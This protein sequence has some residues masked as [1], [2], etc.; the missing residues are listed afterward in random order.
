MSYSELPAEILCEMMS[1]L[2]QESLASLALVD[3]RSLDLASDR[4]ESFKAEVL[5]EPV[6]RYL[7]STEIGSRPK[8]LDLSD[9]PAPSADLE[10]VMK[11]NP[12]LVELNVTNTALSFSTLWEVLQQLRGL[13]TLSFTLLSKPNYQ[14]V[15]SRHHLPT[16]ALFSIKNLT[17]E[18]LPRLW[19][20]DVLVETL[21]RCPSIERVH[22]NAMG[23]AVDAIQ[24]L[25]R[26]FGPPM[27]PL[28]RRTLRTVVLTTRLL[29]NPEPLPTEFAVDFLLRVLGEFDRRIHPWALIRKDSYVYHEGW[30][31]GESDA[32][33]DVEWIKRVATIDLE[34]LQDIQD[35]LDIP[36]KNPRELRIM[37][38]YWLSPERVPLAM[39]AIGRWSSSLVELDMAGCHGF[40]SKTSRICLLSSLKALKNLIVSVCFIAPRSRSQNDQELTEEDREALA[41]AFRKLNLRKL[42][43]NNGSHSY[44]GQG[45]NLSFDQS[46]NL[47]LEGLY[48]KT[49]PRLDELKRLEELTLWGVR[50]ANPVYEF[51]AN[52][53][54]HTLRLKFVCGTDLGDFRSFAKLCEN[55]QTLEFV[56]HWSYFRRSRM[57]NGFLECKALKRL[58]LRTDMPGRITAARVKQRLAAIVSRLDVLHLHFFKRDEADSPRLAE[59]VDQ[60]KRDE[61]FKSLGEVYFDRFCMPFCHDMPQVLRGRDICCTGSLIGTVKPGNW[62]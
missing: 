3:R 27:N 45:N 51:L 25:S 32:E 30:L 59:L 50:A 55:L 26:R 11:C 61:M 41:Q 53:V 54:V 44:A 35:V 60:L 33:P 39:A 58:C 17:V 15:F 22:V 47:C 23:F 37:R 34:S 4:L 28:R 8:S 29:R 19:A 42:C 10:F 38:R 43:V 31:N 49:L 56:D 62:E 20:N 36:K 14:K 52:P 5:S 7:T 46:C 12:Q 48:S 6:R 24:D 9:C 16:C 40:H 21:N 1:Y 57:W 2:D 13:E 18:V